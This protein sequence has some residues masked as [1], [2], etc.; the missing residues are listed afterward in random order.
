MHERGEKEAEKS[1][2]RGRREAEEEEEK[3]GTVARVFMCSCCEK[4]PDSIPTMR[5]RIR[6]A[7]LARARR[8]GE[9]GTPP[10]IEPVSRTSMS[11]RSA[12]SSR[13][14]PTASAWWEAC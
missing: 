9:G 13:L 14:G 4:E 2:K 12:A 5:E 7:D 10:K 11:C 6:I 8:M 3:R 1:R